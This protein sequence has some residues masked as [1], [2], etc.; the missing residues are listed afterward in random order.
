MLMTCKALLPGAAALALSA[1]ACAPPATVAGPRDRG[2]PVSVT[3]GNS[4]EF[5]RQMGLIAAPP[6]VSLVGKTAYFATRS[7]DTTLVLTS[8]SLPNRS[9]TFAREGERYSAPYE[10]RLRLTRGDTE[11]ASISALEVVRVG[12]FKEINRSDESVIFQ[13]F[14][15]IPPGAYSLSLALR[16]VG[17]AR[18]TTQETALVVPRITGTGFSSPL[19]TYESAARIHLDSVPKLLASPRSSAVFGRDSLVAVFLEAYGSGDR[20]PIS[21]VVTND[22]QARVFSDSAVLPRR[23]AMF[24]GTVQVPISTVGLGITRLS[25][26]RRGSS[27]TTGVPIFVSFGEDIPIMPFG[28]MVEYLRFFAPE[29]RLKALRDAPAP[30]RASAWA[31][32]LRDTDPVPESPVNE[33]L[34]AYFGR[35][36][37][38]NVQFANDRNPG[39]LSDRGMVFVALGEPTQVLDRTV[40]PTTT[41]RTPLGEST[42]IQ[43]W[44]YQQ[45]RSQLVFY[46]DA[47]RWRLTRSSEN[48][49][50]AINGRRMAR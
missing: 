30:Q 22:A 48:E 44:G 4:N 6:P 47:G 12:S 29:W 11:V 31:A 45:Y 33:D 28:N 16:D 5:Y 25:F 7:P 17:G 24:S 3:A 35:I 32:F 39:W 34:E 38:A 13:H 26:A 37:Q 43:V 41:S 15:R 14:F 50:W 19:L 21:Y 8:I 2:L 9:L 27:D 10:V 49:F 46:E 18:M 23:G 42:R 1:G 40:S 20:L 36:R